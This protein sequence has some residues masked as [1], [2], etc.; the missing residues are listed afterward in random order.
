MFAEDVTGHALL[1]LHIGSNSF[2]RQPDN[3]FAIFPVF[4]NFFNQPWRHRL[5]IVDHN[6][7]DRLCLLPLLGG[8]FSNIIKQKIRQDDPR[9]YGPDLNRFALYLGRH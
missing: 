5:H 4:Q 1:I 6:I 2:L 9:A 8:H 3:T 7:V